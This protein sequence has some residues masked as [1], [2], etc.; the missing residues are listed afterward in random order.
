MQCTN[1]A[2]VTVNGIHLCRLDF[3]WWIG[4]QEPESIGSNAIE[5]VDANDQSDL[6]KIIQTHKP[7]MSEKPELQ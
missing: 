3:N 4:A 2:Y 5:V 7:Q 6:N 1:T